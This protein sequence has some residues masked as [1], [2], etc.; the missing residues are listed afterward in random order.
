MDLK[1]DLNR[2]NSRKNKTRKR[3]EAKLLDSDLDSNPK[4]EVYNKRNSKDKKKLFKEEMK[5]LGNEMGLVRKRIVSVKNTGLL[6]KMCVS[7]IENLKSRISED[8][9]VLTQ[10]SG[11]KFLF[12]KSS[13][14]DFRFK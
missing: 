13:S 4:T 11:R 1:I 2:K 10:S 5:K 12:P 14:N 7:K 9:A 8:T 3:E 6:C